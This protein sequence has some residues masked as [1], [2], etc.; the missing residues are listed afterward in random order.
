MSPFQENIY[1]SAVM[2]RR[3]CYYNR[4]VALRGAHGK[5]IFTNVGTHA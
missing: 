5:G 4:V 3:Y 2:K 1:L